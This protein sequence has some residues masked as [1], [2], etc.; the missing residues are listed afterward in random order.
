MIGG[1]GVRRD[2]KLANKYFNLAS[3][4][5]HVLAFYNLAQM[6]ATGTGM[7]RSCPTAV[8]LL[9]NVAE[10]GKW[11]DLLMV[12]H[13]NYREGRINEGFVKYALLAEMGYEVA[14][15]NAAFILDKGETTILSEEEGLVRA[16]ALWARAAAQG[17]SA[18]Q[19]CLT[20]DVSFFSFHQTVSYLIKTFFV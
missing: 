12:A 11:S 15:S 1:T 8:E 20:N 2:Y 19:V 6:H 13:T 3:Q 17:Y 10:R 7:M 4:S 14:Q 16:L 18:A 9:K 5:G